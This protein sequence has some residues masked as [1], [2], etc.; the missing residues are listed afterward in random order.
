MQDSSECAILSL[1]RKVFAVT[2]RIYSVDEIRHV[3]A[4]IAQHYGV[5]R[6][7]L[8]GSYARGEAT[9]DSDLDFRVDKG[10]MHG[11]FALGGMYAELESALG[12]KLDLLTTGS[13]DQQFLNRIAPE[14]ILIYA[15]Q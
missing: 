7:F 3:V 13:L 2:D 12:K 14:E 8:F 4:P 11:L 1:E 5:D 10:A 9:S 6:V 15:K